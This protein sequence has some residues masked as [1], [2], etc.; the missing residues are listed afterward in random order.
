MRLKHDNDFS[1]G[2]RIIV[3]MLL[4]KEDCDFDYFSIV[5]SAQG[6]CRAFWRLRHRLDDANFCI[7]RN[8]F[9]GVQPFLYDNGVLETA[10]F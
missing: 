6:Q 4:L 5:V 9:V 2:S 8:T 1:L 3:N 7:K 10:D